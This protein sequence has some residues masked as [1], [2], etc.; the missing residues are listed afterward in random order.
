MLELGVEC[1]WIHE[2]RTQG[3]F[4]KEICRLLVLVYFGAL[5]F[6]F[7]LKYDKP[8]QVEFPDLT[9]YFQDEL[10]FAAH[11]SPRTSFPVRDLSTGK[12]EVSLVP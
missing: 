4:Q 10:F 11:Q 2:I 9:S 5:I 12:P 6:K 3:E 1:N 8:E 7:R